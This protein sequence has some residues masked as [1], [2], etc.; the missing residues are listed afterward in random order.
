MSQDIMKIF[1]RENTHS[2]LIDPNRDFPYGV[3][4]GNC[5][6]TTAGRALNHLFG[7]ISFKWRSRFTEACARSHEWGSPNY[8]KYSPDDGALLL[9]GVRMQQYASGNYYPSGNVGPMNAAV[10]PVTGGMEDWAYAASWDTTVYGTHA[11]HRRRATLNI[12]K[13]LQRTLATC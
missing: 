1:A 10:Y 11:P 13:H 5:M 8:K 9:L 2:G 7:N 4:A 12:Q 6:R 3:K